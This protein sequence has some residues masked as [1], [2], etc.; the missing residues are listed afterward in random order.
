MLDAHKYG[1]VTNM[2]E[3]PVSIAYGAITIGF[4][5]SVLV[6][7]G[8]LILQLRNGPANYG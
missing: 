1:D 5:L 3:I 4:G 2:I 8:Q 7:A 6:L